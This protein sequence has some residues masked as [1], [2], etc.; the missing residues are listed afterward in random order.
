MGVFQDLLTEAVVG[1]QWIGFIASKGS[2]LNGSVG[3][4]Q[5]PGS[6]KAWFQNT[7]RGTTCLLCPSIVVDVSIV[8]APT[9]K[10]VCTKPEARS[11]RYLLY[12]F[13]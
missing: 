5:V 9:S 13:P 4:T 1:G 2:L 8:G 12:V 3:T 7:S 6:A 11:L 10:I